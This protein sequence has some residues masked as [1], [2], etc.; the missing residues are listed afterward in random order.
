MIASKDCPHPN[1]DDGRRNLF[2]ECGKVEDRS[3]LKRVRLMGF[4][5]SQST[6]PAMDMFWRTG[7]PASFSKPGDPDYTPGISRG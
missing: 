1:H 3:A 4:H 6:S 2:C 5:G 7:D